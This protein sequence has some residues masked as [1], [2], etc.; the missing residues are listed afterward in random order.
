V[1]LGVSRAPLFSIAW[2]DKYRSVPERGMICE[3][4]VYSV[5]SQTYD[6]EDDLWTETTTTYIA[7]KA[8][9]QPLRNANETPVPGNATSLQTV[10]VSVPLTN[11]AVSLEPGL[12]M[13]VLVSPLNPRLLDAVYV[14]SQIMDSSNPLEV[15]FYCTAD[16][17]KVA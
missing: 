13:R 4:V 12:Q 2:Q 14:V 9:V 3:V 1:V 8:R 16:Q 15:T 17:E 11:N 7:D 5:D 6:L 10:L